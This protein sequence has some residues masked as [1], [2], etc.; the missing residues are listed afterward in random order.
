MSKINTY[1]DLLAERKKVEAEILEHKQLVREGILEVKEKVEP[2]LNLLPFLNIFKKEEK[3]NSIIKGVASVGIDL[4]VGQKLLAKSNW[5]MRL[6]IPI[7]LKKVSSTVL[8]SR[9]KMEESP[10]VV[11]ELN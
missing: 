7:I 3:E 9:K 6:L 8:S 11:N 1:A 2:F 4:L 10:P 5:L